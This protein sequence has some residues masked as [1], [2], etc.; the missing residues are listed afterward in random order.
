MEHLDGFSKYSSF[1]IINTYFIIYLAFH[2]ITIDGLIQYEEPERRNFSMEAERRERV[3]MRDLMKPIRNWIL[4]RLP[5]AVTVLDAGI[6]TSRALP[7]QQRLN[8]I[9]FQKN[10][11]I[12]KT[13]VA[14]FT[15]AVLELHIVDDSM[16]MSELFTLRDFLCKQ[17]N[18]IN[19]FR[20]A[21]L[22]NKEKLQ[23]LIFKTGE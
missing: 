18:Y 21:H 7:L 17:F 4:L 2:R 8:L 23:H 20:I 11:E 16:A 6:I 14:S 1:F 22:S 5:K 3:R 19:E 10:L 12:I 15:G 13:N 9:H